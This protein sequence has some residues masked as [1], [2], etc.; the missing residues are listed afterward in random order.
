MPGGNLL[1]HVTM[2]VDGAHVLGN[3]EAALHLTEYVSY[4]CSHCAHFEQE[5]GGG[6]KVFLVA[7]NRG[8]IEVRHII[9]DPI[10]LTIALITN[11]VPPQ[12]FF[13]LHEAF[14]RRQEEWMAIAQGMTEAQRAHWGT[15]TDA[16][17]RRAIAGD[18]HFYQFVEGLGLSRVAA[19]RCLADDVLA[20]R[21]VAQTEAADKLGV[22]ST[23]SF[24]IN[25]DVLA[26]THAWETLEPQ[27]QARFQR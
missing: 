3:P 18:L 1:T 13:P 20:R 22:N 25:G 17:R 8:S 9:R 15:G 4:T 27:L 23:P 14:M 24:A 12:R 7:Q 26:G 6:L 19:D 2:T 21:I 16:Q 11:C 5:A 10:D